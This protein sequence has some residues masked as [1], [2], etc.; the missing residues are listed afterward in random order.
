MA[1]SGFIRRRESRLSRAL[2]LDRGITV[3]RTRAAPPKV[4]GTRQAVTAAGGAAPPDRATSAAS[5]QSARHDMNVLVG[6]RD[7]A[8]RPRLR[9]HR[10]KPPPS[11]PV[12]KRRTGPTAPPRQPPTPGH[13]RRTPPPWQRSPHGPGCP[14]H[15]WSP[16]PRTPPTAPAAS[17]TG[18]AASPQPPAGTYPPAPHSAAH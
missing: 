3:G 11:P 9:T 8:Y 18:S 17:A 12:P 5:N 7:C 10:T 13:P 16:P 4:A 1:S 14:C 2:T 15:P 6:H